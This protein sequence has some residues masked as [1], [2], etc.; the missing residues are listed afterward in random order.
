MLKYISYWSTFP[1]MAPDSSRLLQQQEHYALYGRHCERNL[2]SWLDRISGKG[3]LKRSERTGPFT[4]SKTFSFFWGEFGLVF[5]RR[6]RRQAAGGSGVAT[7]LKLLST[8]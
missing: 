6:G 8:F 1:G 2:C 5:R 4:L 3:N 7:G